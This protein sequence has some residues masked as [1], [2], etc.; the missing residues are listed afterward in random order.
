MNKA[1]SAGNGAE[2]TRKSNVI[3]AWVA[4]GIAGFV[5]RFALAPLERVKILY[6]VKRGGGVRVNALSHDSCYNMAATLVRNEGVLSLWK[7]VSVE[8]LR[9]VPY[10][11]VQFATYELYKS[12]LSA[13]MDKKS[14]AIPIVSGFMAGCTSVIVTH[15][16]DT[17]RVRMS[18][19]RPDLKTNTIRSTLSTITT[20]EGVMALY[21]GL[22]PALLGVAPFAGIKFGTY[23]ILKTAIS[24]FLQKEEKDLHAS[25]R[26][27]A[28]GGSGVVA[29]TVVYPFEVVRRRMQA[30]RGSTRSQLS[31]L[32]A[33]RTIMMREGIVNGLYRGLSLNYLK[34]IPKVGIKMGVYDIVRNYH[35]HKNHD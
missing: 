30:E 23:E 19:S 17:I 5:T 1:K 2:V 22:P 21:K 10:T 12:H 33:L 24:R 15:P 3:P 34:I 11:A 25:Y 14:H 13:L 35:L 27:L 28:G 20:E 7:G 6:Q 4:G 8:I 16:L 32:K 26:L 9:V 18:F 31:V 29:V